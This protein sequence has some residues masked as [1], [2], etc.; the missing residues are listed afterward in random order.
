MVISAKKQTVVTIA[1]L[2]GCLLIGI[3]YSALF[4]NVEEKFIQPTI[5]TPMAVPN[6]KNFFEDYRLERD[7]IR[8]KQIELFREVVKNPNSATDIRKDA[9]HKLLD[10]ADKMEKEIYVE[11]VLAAKG[12]KDAVIFI[13]PENV[14]VIINAESMLPQDSEKLLEMVSQLT[15][16]SNED[17]VVISKR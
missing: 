14:T 17:I 13:Q 8:S 16:V 12:F 11:T 7:K 4:H 10:I 2:S 9:Q 6:E 1:I 3:F 15:D 5:S